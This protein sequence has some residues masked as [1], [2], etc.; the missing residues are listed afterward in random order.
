MATSESRIGRRVDATDF[1]MPLS[2]AVTT[3]I[4]FGPLV[5]VRCSKT[6]PPMSLPLPFRSLLTAV[7]LLP[8]FLPAAFGQ[9]PARTVSDT[10]PLA[11]DGEVTVDNHEG[12]ITV[13]TW[14]RDR[15]RYEAE[16]MPTDEDPNAEK[17]TIRTHTSDDRLRLATDHEEGDEESKVFGFDENGFRWGG[18][19]IPD[20]H[21]T[22]TVPRTTVLSLDDHDSKIDVKGLAGKLRIDTHEGPISV[23]EQRGEIVIDNHESSVSI[24]DQEGDVR[25]DTHDGRMNLRRM[26]GRLSVDTHD[27]ELTAE[28]LEGG[29]QFESHD[30]SASVSFAVLSDDVFAETH[31]GDVTLTLPADAGFDLNTDVNDDVDLISDFDL[32][33]IRIGD[34]EDEDNYRGDVNDGG[35]ELYLESQD[36]D[37]T[38]RAR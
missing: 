22:L 10:I 9:D 20:V 30:G 17:V 23:A 18:I 13:T 34:K 6:L 38:L 12:S 15:V 35:P 11:R 5:T 1:R 27:G 36:G 7:I 25:I 28:E 16:I 14:N 4:S 33:P 26:E 3:E 2:I 37:F 8:L 32:A 29:L 19:D 31:D 24:T 21:Y